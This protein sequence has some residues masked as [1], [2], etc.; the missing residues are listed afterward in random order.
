MA[1]YIYTVNR[2]S[3]SRSDFFSIFSG[4]TRKPMPVKRITPFRIPETLLNYDLLNQAIA[5]V[6]P[7]NYNFEIHKTIWR[8]RC[9]RAKRIAL[10]F[11]EGLL[12]FAIPIAELLRKFTALFDN[13]AEDRNEC[14]NY[15]ELDVVIMGDV[16]YGA[17]CVDDYTARALKVDLLVHY[18][19]S[20]LVPLETPS[21][22]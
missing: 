12:M 8:I 19:H 11:P 7:S 21:V 9:L 22:L 14:P 13:N 2:F 5:D 1:E 10:Q 17:C 6:L 3:S 4:F 15:T 16:T 20:C 18:G